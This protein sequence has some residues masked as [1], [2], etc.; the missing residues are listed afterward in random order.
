MTKCKG[1]GIEL[2]NTDKDSVGYVVNLEQ[3]YCQRCFRL[4]HYGDLSNFKTSHVNNKHIYD[5]YNKY[6]KGLFVVI[7]DILDAL[8]LKD[9]HLILL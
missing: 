9:A 1:C 7:V 5:I 2:Q 8:I 3:E 6:S 4:S